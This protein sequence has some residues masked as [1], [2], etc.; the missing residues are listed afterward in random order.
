M[1][2]FYKFLSSPKIRFLDDI[3][4]ELEKEPVEQNEDYLAPKVCYFNSKPTKP[5]G[6]LKLTQ[7]FIPEGKERKYF[8][9]AV[10]YLERENLITT[11]RVNPYK[12][13]YLINY[14]GIVLVK[15]G[16]LGR[17]IFLEKLS[18]ILQ[19]LAWTTVFIAFLVNTL[20]QLNI[21]Q[22][23]KASNR[24]TNPSD[25]INKY[26]QDTIKPTHRLDTL[27]SINPQI[28]KDS[29]KFL[30]DHNVH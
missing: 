21:I 12:P 9:I 22:P 1:S 7:P 2:K 27:K 16:G 25:S 3:L 26:I 28:E 17:K 6:S 10:L 18:G 30:L 5:F 8:R 20:I 24:E 4:I 13:D 29:S 11:L 14:E 15:N 23:F 19:R